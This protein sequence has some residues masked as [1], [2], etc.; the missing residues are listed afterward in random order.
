MPFDLRARL[1]PSPAEIATTPDRPVGIFVSLTLLSPQA[2][3]VPF[4]LR[5]RLW[6]IPAETACTPDSAE[7]G[8][9]VA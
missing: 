5:A 9:F 7:A 1:W 3:T 2:T 4:D 6:Y 8:T